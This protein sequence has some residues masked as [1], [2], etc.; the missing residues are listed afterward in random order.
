ML[1]N[2]PTLSYRRGR[3]PRHARGRGALGGAPG[4]MR[5]V[6]TRRIDVGGWAIV[7]VMAAW[8]VLIDFF[9][10]RWAFPFAEGVRWWEL[11]AL[12][13]V[14]GLGAVWLLGIAAERTSAWLHGR[15]PQPWPG[16]VWWTAMACAV[17]MVIILGVVP[18]GRTA[19]ALAAP[20][21]W[22]ALERDGVRLELETQLAG[23][24]TRYRVTAWC[25]TPEWCR[26]LRGA[27]LTVESRKGG[28]RGVAAIGEASFHRLPGG[29]IRM[30]GMLDMH[31]GAYRRADL[32]DVGLVFF[33]GKPEPGSP[34]SRVLSPES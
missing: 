33:G 16:Q 5:L 32:W 3:A 2:R 14:V 20:R 12:T 10:V 8:I 17:A 13:P 11:M 34:E 19:A 31:P 27:Y 28:E 1:T 15:R 6:P 9:V 30:E 25:G 29:V 21:S 18:T 7:A 23:F 26:R 22:P 4:W 24:E